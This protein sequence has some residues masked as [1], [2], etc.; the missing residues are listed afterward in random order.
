MP[1]AELDF[2][3]FRLICPLPCGQVNYVSVDRP[4]PRS[5]VHRCTKCE[6]D[7]SLE[8]IWPAGYGEPTGAIVVKAETREFRER[9]ARLRRRR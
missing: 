5:T 6:A 3:Q 8:L 1:R 7:L 9:K 2:I 4:L